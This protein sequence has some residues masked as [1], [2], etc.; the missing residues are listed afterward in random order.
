VKTSGGN[1]LYH[2][3]QKQNKNKKE[4]K[5]SLLSVKITAYK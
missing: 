2:K 1:R 4:G 3:K 5:D